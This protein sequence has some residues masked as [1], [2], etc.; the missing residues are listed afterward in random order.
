MHFLVLANLYNIKKDGISNISYD[1]KNKI[2]ES[3]KNKI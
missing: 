2:N 3:V 1:K